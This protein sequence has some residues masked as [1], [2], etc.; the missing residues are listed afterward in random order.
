MNKREEIQRLSKLVERLWDENEKLKNELR[1]ET[2]ICFDFNPL[3][4]DAAGYLNLARG[5]PGVML[6]SY[7]EV[8]IRKVVMLLMDHLG[9]VLKKNP[10]QPKHEPYALERPVTDKKEKK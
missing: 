9:L 7:E 8:P 3:P 4:T 6:P 1:N 2:T 10:P 5:R